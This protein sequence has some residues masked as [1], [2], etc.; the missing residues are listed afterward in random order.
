[1]AFDEVTMIDA[2]AA[3]EAA[4]SGVKS[5][6]GFAKNPDSITIGMLPCVLH[7]PP[8]FTSEPR[9]MH[10]VWKNVITVNSILFVTTRQG[11]GGKLRSIENAAMPFG[12]LWRARFQTD[13]VVSGLLAT[14]GAVKCFLEEGRYGVGGADLTFGDTEF[15]GWTFK[16]TAVNAA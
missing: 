7:Y 15:I 10:N 11:A 9:A 4:I 1:M 6:F 13:S 5:S 3:Q 14:V 12:Y 16:F 8:L 2:I